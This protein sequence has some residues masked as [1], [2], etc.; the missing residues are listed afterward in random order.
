MH[1][2]VKRYVHI[3]NKFVTLE[4]TQSEMNLARVI[5]SIEDRHC[6]GGILNGSYCALSSLMTA[7]SWWSLVYGEVSTWFLTYLT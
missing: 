4:N 2:V 6:Q 7:A 5:P 3:R 1:E